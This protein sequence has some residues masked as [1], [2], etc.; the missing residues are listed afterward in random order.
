MARKKRRHEEIEEGRDN[1]GTRS[2]VPLNAI[3]DVFD[4]LLESITHHQCLICSRRFSHSSNLYRHVRQIHKEEATTLYDP[5]CYGKAKCPLCSEYH[6]SRKAFVQHLEKL[7]KLT[8][9]IER[10]T[11]K[12]KDEFEEW[13]SNIQ[14]AMDVKYLAS[15]HRESG[16]ERIYYKCSHSGT[17]KSKGTGKKPRKVASTKKINAFC[18][19][20]ISVKSNRDGIVNVV[21]TKTHLGHDVLPAIGHVCLICSKSFSTGPNL[22]RHTRKVHKQEPPTVPRQNEQFKC[23]LCL[24][25]H[26]SRIE[27][28]KHVEQAHGMVLEVENHKFN[29]METFEKWL[30]DMQKETDSSYTISRVNSDRTYYQCSRSGYWIPR[31]TGKRK[32]QSR[33]INA[34]CPASVVITS[35]ADESLNV[36]WVKTHIGHYGDS[37]DVVIV[38]N[39]TLPSGIDE[40][41]TDTP[42]VITI[43]NKRAKKGPVRK[44]RRN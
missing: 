21:Y 8:L 29:K 13:L 33:K 6:V 36:K 2:E 32:T 42:V 37:V 38:E 40:I 4:P 39:I 1:Q 35:E 17:F 26:I 18:P 9:D 23:P 20:Q 15:R 22:Y 14:K 10:L 16:E 31:G 30:N 11:F 24:S 43:K 5:K 41:T 44:K 25:S 19:S 27:Y 12:N 3:S 34:F 7:H 28:N